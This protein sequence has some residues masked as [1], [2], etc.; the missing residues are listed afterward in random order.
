MITATAIV[1]LIK[2]IWYRTLVRICRVFSGGVS[3]ETPTIC[4][5]SFTFLPQEIVEMIIVHLTYDTHSLLAC[6]LT[7]YSWY[8][9]AVCHL[10]HTLITQYCFPSIYLKLWWPKPL[11]EANKLGLLPLVKKFHIHIHVEQFCGPGKLSTKQLNWCTLRHFSTLTNVQELGVD[12]LDIPSFILRIQWYFGHFL[13]TVQSLALREPKGSH[14]QIL[15]FVGLFQHLDDLK[16][17]YYRFS[18]QEG[19][20]DDLGLILLFAPPL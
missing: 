10:H 8:I 11:R 18:F 4:S 12:Y 5:S 6:S 9:I 15:Y 20:M 14:C 2:Q 13:P 16:L 7:C 3:P 17:F 1:L 19:P